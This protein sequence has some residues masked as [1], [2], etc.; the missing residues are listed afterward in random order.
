SVK[1]PPPALSL[2]GAL[3]LRALHHPHRA[4]AFEVTCQLDHPALAAILA[5]PGKKPSRHFHPRQAE[6][7][8]VHQGRAVVEVEGHDDASRAARQR[9]LL[10]AGPDGGK[11]EED[12][13]DELC[14]P[15]GAHH[16]WYPSAA[17]V[18]DADDEDWR[19]EGKG[20]VGDVDGSSQRRD[21]RM[22]RVVV[23][24]EATP[25]LFR[26]D[27][28]FFENWYGYQDLCFRKGCA[29]DLIQVMCMF[30]AGGRIFPLPSWVP[31]RRTVAVAVGVALGRW[32]GGLLGY[33]PYY[34]EWTT[35][36][37]LACGK[38]ETSW[39]YRRFADRRVKK[40][41]CAKKH[42]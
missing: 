17:R 32:L 22:T 13:G 31:F 29:P 6:Y 37:Q 14:I 27:W 4:F 30:D 34:R 8:Q 42:E 2:D 1:H 12:G 20:E 35:D 36:W 10:L 23:S 39:F 15:A 26:L 28:A 24:G 38:M 25:D 33:Q 41:S 16:T 11:A 5:D 3:T 18:E 21:T 19:E 9:L 7:I 40:D